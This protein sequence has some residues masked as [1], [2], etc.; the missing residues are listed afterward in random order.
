METPT[1]PSGIQP[2]LDIPLIRYLIVWRVTDTLVRMPPCL[3]AALSDALGEV[4]AERL[5]TSE[6]REWRKTRETWQNPA[7]PAP[8]LMAPPKVAAPWPIHAVLFPHP[9]KQVYGQ[10]EAIV[11]E[12]KLLGPHADH[13][14][15]LE[16]LLPAMEALG[17]TTERRW[18]DRQDLWG[19]FDVHEV[20]AARGARWMP[21]VEE[22]KVN[23]RARVSPVQW[24]DGLTFGADALREY[25]QIVWIT[26]FDLGEGAEAQGSR[27]AAEQGNEG[28]EA[29]ASKQ[30]G[31]KPKKRKGQPARQRENAK[32][33]REERQRRRQKITEAEIPT[34]YG[35]V[36][37]LVNRIT[38]FLPGKKP[39]VEQ[40]WAQVDPADVWAMI[41]A[42]DPTALT[43]E[44]E[45]LQVTLQ[46]SAFTAP[47]KGWPGKW[48]GKEFFS[49]PLPARLLPYLELAS[50]L[51]V[52][53]DTHFGCGTFKLE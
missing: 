8:G 17:V 2:F 34:L 38:Q 37:A 43:P 26:P 1:P 16:T 46:S 10:G 14:L 21:V 13:G 27:G 49:A 47:P 35:I 41:N 29:Q 19:H 52:G 48:I 51:H 31:E 30:N 20:Y 36:D 5:P 50:I 4:V 3:S 25:R 7:P 44:G 28:A 15:F 12:L 22:G 39:S 6:A 9:G 53:K 23:L 45:E 33:K 11:W 24:R 40:A 18:R 32:A 42:E